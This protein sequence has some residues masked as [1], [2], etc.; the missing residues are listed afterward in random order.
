MGVL[1]LMTKLALG[2]EAVVVDGDSVD[3]KISFAAV[4][5]NLSD[6]K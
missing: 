6:G 5:A 2:D 1:A 4:V 3:I